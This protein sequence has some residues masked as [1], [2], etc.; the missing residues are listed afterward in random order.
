L[1]TPGGQE[2]RPARGLGLLGAGESLAALPASSRAALL[3]LL[4]GR[5]DDAIA[6]TATD[7]TTGVWCPDVLFVNPA[8]QRLTGFAAEEVIG[9]TPAVWAPSQPNAVVHEAMC[10]RLEIGMPARAELPIRTATGAE[11]WIDITVTPLDSDGGRSYFLEVSRDVTERHHLLAELAEREGQLREA[12]ALTNVG[13]WEW[14]I[15]AETVT[16]SPELFRLHGVD[17]DDGVLLTLEAYISR[18]HP[19][20]RQMIGD[21]VARALRSGEGFVI[22]HRTARPDGELQWLQSRVR[23]VRDERDQRS[24][25]MLGTCQDVTQQKTS[26]ETLRRQ[27]LHDA[28]T[29][30]PNRI[31][32][33]DRLAHAVAHADRRE[34]RTAVLFVDIDD[35]KAVND[36]FGH[37]G[38]DEALMEVARRL[39]SSLRPSDTLARVGGDEFVAVCEDV[40]SSGD[41]EALAGRIIEALLPAVKLADGDATVRVSVGVSVGVRGDR[42]DTLIRRADAAMYEAKLAGGGAYR[43]FDAAP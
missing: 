18:I 35:F 1:H 21:I 16:W 2:D 27:A 24:I 42:P 17:P 22:E 31:L 41:A 30:L 33:A 34:S 19:D 13:S 39:E 14:D 32:L 12:Q 29:G 20:D 37:H 38:G 25:R 40:A 26:E 10:R 36:R 8:H 9:R 7:A 15:D 43:R 23:V 28:L 4:L 3:D 6:I 11:V 5:A